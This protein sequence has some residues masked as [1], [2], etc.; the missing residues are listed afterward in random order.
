MDELVK[1][2]KE[3][4]YQTG[5]NMLL[6]SGNRSDVIIDCS[7][8]L[9]T[10][11]GLSLL[12]DAIRLKI[13][14]AGPF[15]NQVAGPVSGADP[16]C[17]AVLSAFEYKLSLGWLSI[18]KEEKQHG[19]DKGRITGSFRKGDRVLIVD[20]VL[21]TGKSLIDAIRVCKEANL[22]VIGA[23]VV[24]DREEY[25]GRLGVEAELID[26]PLYSLCTKTDIEC[27]II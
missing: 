17:S 7:L 8:S 21:T 5:E 4:S 12:R 13:E 10:N 2:I 26:A 22:K 3:R 9:R 18:R 20:D 24:V 16:I 19:F 6:S 15:F 11:Y 23:L 14:S 27:Y 25:D 1:F